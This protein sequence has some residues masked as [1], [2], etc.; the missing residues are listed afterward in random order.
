VTAAPPS[1]LRAVDLL[2]LGT[3]G[4][5]S[6]RIRAG[7]SML[8]VAVG[9][10]AVVAVLGIA[11]SSQADLLARI[12]ALGTNLLTVS[13]GNVNGVET[14]LPATSA[15]MIVATEGVLAAAATS[16]LAGLHVYRSDRIEVFRHAGTSVRA[17]DPNVLSTLDGRLRHGT[18]LTEATGRYPATVLGSVVADSLG[19]VDLSGHPRVW[20]G[21]RWY[22]VVGILAPFELAPEIDRS[23]LIGLAVAARDFGYDGHPTRIY[24]RTE[25]G[26][27]E[28]TAGLLPRVANPAHPVQVHVSRPSDALAAR[29]AVADSTT[30]LFLGLGAVALLVGGIGIA[31]VMVISVLERRGEIGLR[32]ALGA[33]RRHIAGQFLIESLALG[34]GGG[35]AGVLLG[36]AATY[37]M[38]RVHGWQPLIPP[39]AVGAG[40]AA[41]VGVGA[42]AGLY[43]AL[44]AAHLAPTDALRTT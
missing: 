19:I 21:Q 40:L 4:L 16:E 44:R 14:P 1:R 15:S 42:L 36:A 30:T 12:D 2:A 29:L 9:I 11:R 43:P 7:L 41:A 25:T 31:N 35:M 34:A 28:Q 20:L 39:V 3:I 17:V 37:A 32:R 27:T 5:R 24:V 22:T 13:A 6:R 23:A 18:F 8:G 33:A 38:A 10:A 26:R